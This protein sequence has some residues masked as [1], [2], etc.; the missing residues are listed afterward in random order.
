MRFSLLSAALL[1]ASIL[2]AAWSVK[3]LRIPPQS[4][5][6]AATARHLYTWGNGLHQ[7]NKKL[8]HEAYGPGGCLADIN[9]DQ[10][11]DLVLHRL[12]GELIWLEGPRFQTAHIIDTES[13]FAN[14][15]AANLHGRKGILLTHR[16]LQVRFYITPTDTNTQA[17]WA[18]Q[19]IYSFYTASYQAG[20]QLA[21]I[22]ADGFPDI[23]CGNYW[24]QSP[25]Q[26]ELPWRLYAINT[27][28]DTPESAH[29]RLQW[30][31][32]RLLASQGELEQ[33]KVVLFTPPP[34]PTQLW[35]PA[36]IAEYLPHPHA[37][38]RGNDTII[39]EGTRLWLIANQQK[40][41]LH[42]SLAIHTL[43]ETN[44]GFLA[45]GASGALRLKQ[46]P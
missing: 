15:L 12:P 32:G 19:E 36:I 44:D 34:D 31:N 37:A 1:S 9:A 17:K 5:G 25:P 7:E 40:R 3:P 10:H 45:I 14:C 6:A 11:P 16:G 42:D 35:R 23:L 46:L 22:N 28:N 38:T 27:Y 43:L 13:D 20:L 24:I 39:A 26:P 33:G 4:K 2:T 41:L 30:T 8:R 29:M 18:Y 21:D